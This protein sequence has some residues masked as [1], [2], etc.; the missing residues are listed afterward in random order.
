MKLRVS[1]RRALESNDA[2]H[3]VVLAANGVGT[4]RVS[5]NTDDG[6]GGASQADEGSH[7]LEDNAQQADELPDRVRVSLNEEQNS[8]TS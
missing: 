6:D 8:I 2:Y 5:A 3:S 4:A 7:I 1:K